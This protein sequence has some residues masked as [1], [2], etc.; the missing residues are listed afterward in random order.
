MVQYILITN[1][2]LKAASLARLP[3]SVFLDTKP[4]QITKR[5][6]GRIIGGTNAKEGEFPWMVR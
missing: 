2:F 6:D 3:L 4:S 1:T 5:R